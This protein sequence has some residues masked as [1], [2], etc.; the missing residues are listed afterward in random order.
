[1]DQLTALIQRHQ[2]SFT[3][4]V[5]KV[6][7]AVISRPKLFAMHSAKSVG[8]EIGVSET[9][10]IRFS[11]IIGLSGFSELQD[12]V[13]KSLYESNQL[14][15][16]LNTKINENINEHSFKRS[17]RED[18]NHI[19]EMMNYISA[20]DLDEVVTRITSAQQVLVYGARGSFSL[21]N[22]FTFSLNLVHGKALL[23]QE[24]VANMKLQMNDLPEPSVLV[25]FSF[26]RYAEKTIQLAQTAKEQGIF[27]IAFTDS[28]VSPIVKLADI[29]LSTQFE[30]KSILDSAPVVMSLMNSI[31]HEV[32]KR[33]K[34]TFKERAEIF[35]LKD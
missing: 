24:S 13:Q 28:L 4:G 2:A 32:P 9:T 16:Y 11:H 35:Y 5:K 8:K 31:I 3:T 33:N 19:A 12:K 10:V 7:E 25:V 6:A 17:M 1:M 34:S 18:V 22:W 14:T 23:F 27:I 21:A 15:N 26:H 20:K 29:T 30:I